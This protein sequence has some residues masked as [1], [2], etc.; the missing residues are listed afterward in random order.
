MATEI[1]LSS[2]LASA[3]PAQTNNA[4]AVILQTDQLVASSLREL[5]DSASLVFGN[6]SDVES[7]LLSNPPFAASIAAATLATLQDINAS[8]SSSLSVLLPSDD[9]LL[10]GTS[11][12]ATAQDVITNLSILQEF[13]ESGTV[14]LTLSSTEVEALVA[15]FSALFQTSQI[16]DLDG[17]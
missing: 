13:T 8:S 4:D 11:Q 6:S 10:T 17:V 14:T 1:L 2:L 7:S 15:S 3:S 16:I 12:V 9:S 5:F